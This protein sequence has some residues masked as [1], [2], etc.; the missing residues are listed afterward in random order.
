MLTFASRSWGFQILLIVSTQAM[1]LGV[2]GILRRYLVW[3]A[4]MVQIQHMPIHVFDVISNN[5][6]GLAPNT[7]Y[8]H[9]YVF[10]A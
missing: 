6:I 7:R 4:A 2:A 10:A 9:C 8:H 3:P 1:G 5:F